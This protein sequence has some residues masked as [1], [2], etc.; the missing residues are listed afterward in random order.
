[1]PTGLRQFAGSKLKSRAGTRTSVNKQHLNGFA[2]AV[3]ARAKRRTFPAHYKQTILAAADAAS[4]PGAIGAL[5]RS[6]GLCSSH[7]TANAWWTRAFIG[8]RH[9]ARPDAP[10]EVG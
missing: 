9:A 6:E 7:L 1:M 10:G 4:G 2:S 8:V 5:L 3:V